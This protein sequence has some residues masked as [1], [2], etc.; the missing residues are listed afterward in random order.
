MV[1]YLLVWEI[2]WY[3]LPVILISILVWKRYLYAKE[4]WEAAYQGKRKLQE[5]LE[6]FEFFYQ[7]HQ[8]IEAALEELDRKSVV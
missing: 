3:L 4:R 6:S 8:T 1:Y 7:T 2:E 5:F